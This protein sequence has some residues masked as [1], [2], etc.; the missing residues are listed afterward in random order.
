MISKTKFHLKFTWELL[1]VISLDEISMSLPIRS[2]I[3]I[4]SRCPSECS[5]PRLQENIHNLTLVLS[6]SMHMLQ[7]RRIYITIYS[8][9]SL[10]IIQECKYIKEENA[11]HFWSSMTTES[12]STVTY[13]VIYMSSAK[14]TSQQKDKVPKAMSFKG[15]QGSSY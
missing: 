12:L 15:K 6:N 8:S 7:Y 3:L 9:L 1:E 5:L 10:T 4:S 2:K 13:R 14:T 11:L